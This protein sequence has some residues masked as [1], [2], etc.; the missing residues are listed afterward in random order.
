MSS[1]FLLIRGIRP[2]RCAMNSSASTEVLISISTRS[3]ARVGTSAR[4]TR[5][6]EFAKERETEERVKET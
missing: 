6:R 3:M 2:S 5:R 1:T 4:M